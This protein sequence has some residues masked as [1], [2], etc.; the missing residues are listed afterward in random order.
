[1]V[2]P[3]L[4]RQL[5]VKK[6]LKNVEG[7]GFEIRLTNPLSDATIIKPAKVSLGDEKF[8]KFK[9]I[10]EAGEI[11]NDSVSEKNPL[12]FAVKTNVT[13]RFPRESPL[14]PEK[15]ALKFTIQ[16]EEYGELKFK[17]KDRIRE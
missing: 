9:I 16:S 15:Y 4:L 14:P 13:L 17:I 8:K 7:I 3:D 11:D 12:K 1:M 2:S 10:T 5:Y 6:S